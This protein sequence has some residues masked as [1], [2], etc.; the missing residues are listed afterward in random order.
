MKFLATNGSAI[1]FAP[2]NPQM[3]RALVRLCVAHN[4]NKSWVDIRSIYLGSTEL[5]KLVL[6]GFVVCHDKDSKRPHI[7]H[8]T[9][10]G[11]EAAC[12]RTPL[13]KGILV[14]NGALFATCETSQTLTELLDDEVA[15]IWAD[16]GTANVTPPVAKTAAAE[17]ALPPPPPMINV[18]ATGAPPTA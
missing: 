7:F 18:A 14:S 9:G 1:E 2:M 13:P 15:K 16:A 17:P 4:Q 6:W 11:W 10:A 5:K 3:A 8:P 12:G